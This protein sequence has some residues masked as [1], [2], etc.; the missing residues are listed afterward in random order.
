VIVEGWVD[1]IP[2][3]GAKHRQGDTWIRFDP[4]MKGYTYVDGV[5]LAQEVPYDIDALAQSI[6]STVET[7]AFGNVVSVDLS[8]VDRA[9]K[10]Q[11]SAELSH[12][13]N[14][15]ADTSLINGK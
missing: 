1:M 3:M 9:L 15:Y 4:S 11:R 14:N 8:A 12:I 10:T 2:S 5:N 7:D 6:L 13:N